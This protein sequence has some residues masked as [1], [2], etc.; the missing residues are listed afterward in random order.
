MK[1]QE[2]KPQLGTSSILQSPK[3]GLWGHISNQDKEPKCET[4]V[5][6][7]PVNISNQDQDAKPQLG[8]SSIL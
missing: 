8:T 4:W 2:A 1:D 7:R 6:Q 3:S 5:Y